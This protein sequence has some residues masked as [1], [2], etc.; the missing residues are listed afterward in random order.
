MDTNDLPE[1]SELLQKIYEFAELLSICLSYAKSSIFCGKSEKADKIAPYAQDHQKGILK[2]E[3]LLAY[4]LEEQIS[5]VKYIISLVETNIRVQEFA[6]DGANEISIS[7]IIEN[8][9]ELNQDTEK[10]LRYF[11]SNMEK[12]Y[13]IG[14]KLFGILQELQNFR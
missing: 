5:S 6:S 13:A 3:I 10:D 2:E 8:I 7:H 1:E 11:Y 14:N 12:R 9:N 4:F